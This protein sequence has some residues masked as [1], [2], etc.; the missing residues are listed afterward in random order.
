MSL[1]LIIKLRIV[2]LAMPPEAMSCCRAIVKVADSA[3]LI[4]LGV[5]G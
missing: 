3:T 5:T 4:R 2:S 1:L